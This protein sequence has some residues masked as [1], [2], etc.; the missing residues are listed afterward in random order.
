MVLQTGK[1]FLTI[2]WRIRPNRRD[3]ALAIMKVSY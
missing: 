2:S 3:F 1:R